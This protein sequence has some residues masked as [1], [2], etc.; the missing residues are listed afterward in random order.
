MVVVPLDAGTTVV[1]EL[2]ATVVEGMADWGKRSA[3]RVRLIGCGWGGEAKWGKL[4]TE[5][6]EKLSFF[7]SFLVEKFNVWWAENLKTWIM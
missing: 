1:L 6:C 7:W 4:Q 3:E 5:V 2:V